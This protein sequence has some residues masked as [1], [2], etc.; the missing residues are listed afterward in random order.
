MQ[1]IRGGVV[2]GR[3]VTR[4]LLL[5]P[6]VVVI[7]SGPGGAIA[8]AML[9]AAGRQVVVLEEGGWYESREFDPSEPV[10]YQRLFQDSASRATDDLAIVI[11]Q[12][13]GAGG[14]ST[15]NWMT[16]LRTPPSTL[17]H[18]RSRRGVE[19]IDEAALAPHFDTIERRLNVHPAEPGDVSRNNRVLLDGAARLG[20]PTIHLPRNTRDCTNLGLCT[21]GCPIDAKMSAQQ[22]YLADAVAN[23]T[24]I[25]ADVRVVRLE[26]RG[27][28][29]VRVH[30]EL[31]DRETKQ[32]RGVRVI[33]QPKEVFLAAGALNSP[34]LLLR[35][36][37][38]SAM[39]GKRTWLHPVVAMTALFDEPIEA[40]SGSPQSIAVDASLDRGERMGFFLEAPP[41]YPILAA[42]AAPWFGERHASLMQQ[43]RNICGLI[44]LTVDGFD[45]SERGGTVSVERSGRMR[46]RYE[47]TPRL[48]EAA[49]EAMKMIAHIQLAAGARTV[50]SLHS[51]PVVITNERDLAAIDDAPFGPGR[52][53]V[54][55]A[56]QMGGCAMGEDRRSSVTNSQ[57]RHHDVRNLT[58]C[59]GSLFPTSL[60]VNPMLSIYA[61]AAHVTAAHLAR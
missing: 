34:A 53:S 37:I 14:G 38:E 5:E 36:G 40:W 7:G 32:P 56:H 29:I 1:S 42:L 39:T 60:G 57:G 22:T 6:D 27:N 12:G 46:F 24:T 49:N 23:G 31:V 45:E 28:E 33:V 16:S 18:W 15:V 52:L 54:F 30:G 26:R 4:D 44:G 47:F 35:S 20:I 41:L 43:L 61:L 19:G 8:A 25:Y 51:E 21:M 11:L 50:M 10:A 2:H 59:D 3:D 9:S 17:H 48:R 13:R 55:T 58:I